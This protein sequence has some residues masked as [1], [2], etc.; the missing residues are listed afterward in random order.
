MAAA[1]KYDR[2]VQ[3]GTQNRSGVYNHAAREYIKSG[4]IKVDKT[5]NSTPVTFHDSCNNARS[6]GLYEEPRE[7]LNLVCT[8][9]RE[10]YPNRGENWCCGGGGS[11][12]PMW[13]P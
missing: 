11:C 10:M 1:T 7:L 2:I 12:G 4:K 6:C 3:L 13:S 5:K 8:D 9:F